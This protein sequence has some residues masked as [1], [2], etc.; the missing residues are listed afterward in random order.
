MIRA[1][2]IRTQM[3]RAAEGMQGGV[4]KHLPGPVAAPRLLRY[5]SRAHHRD[6]DDDR[7]QNHRPH[8][9]STDRTRGRLCSLLAEKNFWYMD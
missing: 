4:G 5:M 7:L 3:T 9:P 8:N 1:Q 6:G 2:M